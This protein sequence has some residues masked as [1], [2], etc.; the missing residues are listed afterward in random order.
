MHPSIKTLLV[1][2]TKV[3]EELTLKSGTREPLFESFH[4][5][6]NKMV[7][8]IIDTPGLFER[9]GSEIDIRDNGVPRY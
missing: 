7:L 1:N 2:P 8:N 3:P 4:A 9:G 5:S 6:D